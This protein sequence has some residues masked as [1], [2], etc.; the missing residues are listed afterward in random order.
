M[1]VY[2]VKARFKNFI[3]VLNRLDFMAEKAIKI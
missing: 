2:L 1:I 3:S